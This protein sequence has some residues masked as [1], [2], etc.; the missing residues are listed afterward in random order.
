MSELPLHI[1]AR[2][3]V[4][5]WECDTFIGASHYCAVVTKVDHKS[6]YTVMPKVEKKPLNKSAQPLWTSSNLCL[7]GMSILINNFKA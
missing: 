6:G 4:D 5:Y 1:E 3:Q 7:L 2:K